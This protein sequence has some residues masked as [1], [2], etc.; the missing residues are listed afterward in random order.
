MREG[1][2][3]EYEVKC[4]VQSGTAFTFDNKEKAQKKLNEMMLNKKIY[5]VVTFTEKT[6][7]TKDLLS[8]G[9]E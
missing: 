9:R 3:V 8:K 7:T 4:W 2:I 1:T 5:E 6:I